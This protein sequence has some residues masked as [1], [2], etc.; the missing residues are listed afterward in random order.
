[1]ARHIG[2][3]VLTPA[4]LSMGP[5]SEVVM[6][7][8]FDK[9]TPLWYYILKEAEIMGSG[10]RLGVVGSTIVAETFVGL[11]LA[12]KNSYLNNNTGWQPTLKLSD[13]SDVNTL[14]NFIRY[15]RGE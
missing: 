13:G 8:G 14:I 11:L 6:D 5:E 2:V 4:E 10:E 1:V 15:G 3:Q 9:N 12:D 7:A